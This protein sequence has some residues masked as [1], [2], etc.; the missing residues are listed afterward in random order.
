MQRSWTCRHG[1]HGD[2]TSLWAVRPAFQVRRALGVRLQQLAPCK[3][4]PDVWSLPT[5]Q[6]QVMSAALC[7]VRVRALTP[8]ATTLRHLQHAAQYLPTLTLHTLTT[9][10]S[11]SLDMWLTKARPSCC[12]RDVPAWRG[13]HR[14]RGSASGSCRA[15]SSWSTTPA[16]CGLRGG[17]MHSVTV[18]RASAVRMSHT[19][20]TLRLRK[21]VWEGLRECF[22]RC[23]IRCVL[24]CN[25]KTHAGTP[26]VRRIDHL[27]HHPYE[28]VG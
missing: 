4:T 10:R 14:S 9:Q 15:S 13:L 25:L 28:Q 8:Y 16:I 12:T 20:A 27:R 5:G 2:V 7:R 24:T 19:Q 1:D 26:Y 3:A 21:Q 22:L 23:S 6:V 17:S 11:Y 18:H